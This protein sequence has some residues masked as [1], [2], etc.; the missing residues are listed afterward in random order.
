[1]VLLE[2]VSERG[3]LDFFSDAL[4]NGRWFRVL[5]V[6]NA[7]PAKSSVS[8]PIHRYRDWGRS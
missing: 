3:S 4:S 6:V 7:S 8:L 5:A 2:A 1:M